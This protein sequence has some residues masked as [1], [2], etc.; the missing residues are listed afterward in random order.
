MAN[1]D[2]PR[3]YSLDLDK[4]ALLNEPIFIL[5]DATREGGLPLHFTV[6]DASSVLLVSRDDGIQTIETLTHPKLTQIANTDQQ[7]IEALGVGTE[8]NQYNSA[9]VKL[10]KHHNLLAFPPT[11]TFIGYAM[12]DG[13]WWA[14]DILVSDHRGD[15]FTLGRRWMEE[16]C[17]KLGLNVLP[18]VYEGAP[19]GMPTALPSRVLVR[20][21]SELTDPD[22]ARPMQWVFDQ[23]T[24]TIPEPP[25]PA[26]V[27]ENTRK[28]DKYKLKVRRAGNQLPDGARPLA[29][30]NETPSGG[31]PVDSGVLAGPILLPA[32]TESS[33]ELVR[34]GDS[35]DDQEPSN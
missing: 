25:E 27:L 18:P 32:R 2:R 14:E 33:R 29:D 19:A 5:G 35:G 10:I 21:V 17:K 8:T 9:I 22:S 13:E 26:P 7:V 20:T 16:T 11:H 12:L 28:P 31:S 15:G 4:L 24:D 34:E 6:G 30:L 1:F 23:D 3:R